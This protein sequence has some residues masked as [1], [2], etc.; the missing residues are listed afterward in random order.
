MD[1]EARK[2]ELIKALDKLN[3]KDNYAYHHLTYTNYNGINFNIPNHSERNNMIIINEKHSFDFFDNYWKDSDNKSE[4]LSEIELNK[5]IEQNEKEENQ[6][7]SSDL[8]ESSS[9]HNKM[10][11]DIEKPNIEIAFKK[12]KKHKKV[13]RTCGE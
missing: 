1:F 4:F 13:V 11:V 2:E 9:L 6:M 5:E 3:V 12:V 8:I 7:P 10:I